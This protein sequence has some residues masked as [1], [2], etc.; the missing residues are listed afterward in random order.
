[1][2]GRYVRERG[3]LTLENAVWKMSGFPAARLGLADRGQIAVGRKADIVVFDDRTVIDR[4][5][6]AN[7][8]QF[9]EGFRDV[10]VNGVP[11][12]RNGQLTGDRPGRALRRP[13]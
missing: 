12:M 9:S 6:F 8:H 3:V 4:A 11:V 5:D 2:L 1:V 10:V 7:P 13:Q